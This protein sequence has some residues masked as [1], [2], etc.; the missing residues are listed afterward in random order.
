MLPKNEFNRY[1]NAEEAAFDDNFFAALSIFSAILQT[2]NINQSN[3]QEKQ[4]EY[5]IDLI[6]RLY[7]KMDRLEQKIDRLERLTERGAYN[8]R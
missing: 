8:G 1:A 2:Y 6:E 5:T 4:G 7:R 3:N